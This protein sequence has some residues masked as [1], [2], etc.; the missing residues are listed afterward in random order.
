MY[1]QQK[2]HLLLATDKVVCA[3]ASTLQ[4]FTIVSIVSP[5]VL[6][7]FKNI[8]PGLQQC[9]SNEGSLVENPNPYRPYI[10]LIKAFESDK[11]LSL[12]IVDSSFQTYLFA[13][14]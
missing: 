9:A 14:Y 8:I 6:I 10:F 11:R 13:I 5:D 12:Q 2:Q 4:G 1:Y 7:G 3:V